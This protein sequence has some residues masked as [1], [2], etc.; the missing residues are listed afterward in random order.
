[1][2]T[3]G[4]FAIAFGATRAVAQASASD[5]QILTPARL[6][7]IGD[8]MRPAASRTAQLGRGDG[9]TYA[10]TQRD[11]SG[12][13]E[14]HRDWN[15]VFV[16]QSGK[17]TLFSGGTLVGATEVSPGE[18]RGGMIRDGEHRAIGPGDVVIVPAGTP[19]QMLLDPGHRIS[20][21]AFKVAAASSGA[22]AG[23]RQP[24]SL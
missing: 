18:M 2:H 6:K 21:L 12:G 22:A 13:I 7:A 3:C 4:V 10:L 11:S 9:Y 17:A 20:Y 19:H 23:K 16:V 5:A 24:G 8:S 15:D 14:S 1:V